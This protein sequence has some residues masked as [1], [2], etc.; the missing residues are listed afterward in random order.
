MPGPSAPRPKAKLP[1][2][3]GKAGKVKA[4][5]RVL[6]IVFEQLMDP[7]DPK[8]HV[9]LKGLR[10][11]AKIDHIM[12]QYAQSYRYPKHVADEFEFSCFEYCRVMVTLIN[13][14]HKAVPPVPVFNYTIKAHYLMHIGVCARYTN[15]SFGSCYGGE[16]LMQTCKQMFQASCKGSDA[17][18]ACN[19]AVFRFVMGRSLAFGNQY[20]QR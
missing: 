7:L 4:L 11:S 14:Y 19:E 16:T 5:G 13:Q 3:K 17:L 1:L 10:L 6:P 15:P 2:L 8:H 20:G 18:S 9:V 12:D